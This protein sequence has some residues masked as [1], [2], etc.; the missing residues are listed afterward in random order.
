MVEWFAIEHGYSHVS[1]GPLNNETKRRIG[2]EFLPVNAHI[3]SRD[4][5]VRLVTK[6][7]FIKNFQIYQ[8]PAIGPGAFQKP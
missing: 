4:R 3:W 5:L 6:L 8:G 7:L 2:T 1:L